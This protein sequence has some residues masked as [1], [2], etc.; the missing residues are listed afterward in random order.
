MIRSALRATAAVAMALCVLAPIAAGA[1]AWPTKPVKF[2][3]P[4]P[5]GGSTD[6]MA[7]L[8]AAKLSDSLGQP[9]VVENRSGASGTIGTAF[10]AKSP[11]DGYTFIFVFDYHAVNP[12]LMPN[13]PFDTVKDLAPVTL[14]GTAPMAIATA[15]GKPYK[16]FVDVVAAAKVKPGAVSIGSVG[17]GSLGHLTMVLVQQA[18]GIRLIH[19]PYKGGGPMTADAVGGQIDLAIGSVAV[20]TPHVTGGKLRAIAVTGDAR[21]RALP[22]VPTLAEQGLPGFSALAWWAVFAPA[23]VPKPVIDKFH[24][25]LVKAFNLPDVRKLLTETLGIDLVVSPP[26]GL[27]QW[28]ET[29]MQRWGKVV[30]ENNIRAD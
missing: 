10:V 4:Y 23:G 16:S 7:R 19:I 5:P 30:R 28:L 20:I 8:I 18:S 2:I 11:A 14:I 6:P 26:E 27:A 29:Q 15:A 17:N 3:V 12:F 9:F 24:A 13:L 25:E 22:D 21:S 1:Q